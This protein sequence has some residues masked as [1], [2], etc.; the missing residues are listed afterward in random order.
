M[1]QSLMFFIMVGELTTLHSST[2]DCMVQAH[3][4]AV[5]DLAKSDTVA[6]QVINCVI[7]NIHGDG[8]DCNQQRRETEHLSTT[9][10]HDVGNG[11]NGETTAG[12]LTGILIEN[13]IFYDIG[14]YAV[15]HM[16]IMTINNMA[17]KL[18]LVMQH[19]Q[20]Q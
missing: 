7:D 3:Q 4:E 20:L 5:M 2:V 8:I 13:C 11:I 18:V 19:W 1:A 6:H 15:L 14:G 17:H 12:L 16:Q 9:Q 10:S